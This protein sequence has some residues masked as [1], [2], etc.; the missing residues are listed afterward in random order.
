MTD[1]DDYESCPSGLC[2]EEVE[3]G[4]FEENMED[5][6]HC[7]GTGY[8]VREHCCA[9]GSGP[10]CVCCRTC[11]AECVAECTCPIPTERD[12]KTVMV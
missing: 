5:C 12:G 11:A 7:G 9:C 3:C 10:Y 4:C 1:N 2:F 6:W 8:R